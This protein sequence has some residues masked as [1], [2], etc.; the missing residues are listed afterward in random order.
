LL[1]TTIY[2]IGR[3]YDIVA[4]IGA[5]PSGLAAIRAL[6]QE[7]AFSYIRCFERKACVGGL[8]SVIPFDYEV[9]AAQ[10]C[11]LM[12]SRAYDAEPDKFSTPDDPN[13]STS[14]LPPELQQ[15]EALLLEPSG[16][17][18]WPKNASYDNLDT[19]AGARTMPYTHTPL[20]F[21]NSTHS[22][23]KFGK[24]NSTRPRH[25]V[26]SY[27]EDLWK[28]FLYLL[29]LSTHVENVERCE[30]DGKW[31]VTLR[32]TGVGADGGSKLPVNDL[33][34][35]ESFDAVIV[36]SGHFSVPRI[37]QIE[38][39]REVSSRYPSKFEH[40][41]SWRSAENY[42]D[43]A[44]TIHHATDYQ[45]NSLLQK[46][47]VVGGGVSAADLA[48]EL[49]DI[50][51]G[52]LY[53]SHRNEL[54]FLRNALELPGIEK[55]PELIR[56]YSDD[57][58]RV[59]AEFKDGSVISDFDKIIFATGYRLSYPFLPFQAVTPQNRLSGFYQHIF[60]VGDPSLAVIGQV[61]DALPLYRS[62]QQHKA[63]RL[64]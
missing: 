7:R 43:K 42:V 5:G 15:G 57:D 61:S 13:D 1:I 27:L 14:K 6:S 10:T 33:W 37:P 45:S 32:R 29:S 39:L 59:H 23:R 20:P 31:I 21:A 53:L 51:Q 28:P 64:I 44:G 38:G 24:N 49:H 35:Q 36:A 26:L 54:D 18:P 16:E 17:G 25:A 30:A 40:S 11:K 63:N 3:K 48:E 41:K 47:I 19:N 22:I 9:L 52:S 60:R 8:W 62:Q 4:V 12:L 46:V 55:R 2:I 58:H 34:W 56:V 50:V